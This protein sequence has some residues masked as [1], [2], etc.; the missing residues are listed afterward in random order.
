MNTVCFADES[1]HLIYSGGDDDFCKV[2]PNKRYSANWDKNH[3]I[4]SRTQVITINNFKSIRNLRSLQMLLSSCLFQR[5]IRYNFVL[6][7]F[8]TDGA[9]QLKASQQGCLWVTLKASPSLTAV[10]M[11]VI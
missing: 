2:I 10:E 3:S 11:V 4:C 6:H 8:G 7:R 9:S 1:G 5:K